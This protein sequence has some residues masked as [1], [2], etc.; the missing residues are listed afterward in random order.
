MSPERDLPLLVRVLREG[1][2]TIARQ[3]VWLASQHF[4]GTQSDRLRE[5]SYARRSDR[6]IPRKLTDSIKLLVGET[7]GEFRK[8][9]LTVSPQISGYR[10]PLVLWWHVPERHQ[11]HHR[12]KLASP[13]PASGNVT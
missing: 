13:G 6:P 10:T 4:D 9:V 1:T 3:R 11:Q 7:R 2:P 12:E 5:E 8:F